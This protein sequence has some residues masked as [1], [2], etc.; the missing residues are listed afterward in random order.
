ML[1]LIKQ[2]LMMT[3]TTINEKIINDKQDYISIVLSVICV[4]L[5]I[6]IFTYIVVIFRF[7][8][9]ERKL[10]RKA[11]SIEE[12]SMHEF[13]HRLYAN[14]EEEENTIFEVVANTS[15]IFF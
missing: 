3:L 9:K 14:D 1:M 7:I 10:F 11:D 5:I 12:I 4:L 6:I 13:K 8:S 15:A 2:E